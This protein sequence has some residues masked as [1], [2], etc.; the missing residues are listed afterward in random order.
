MQSPAAPTQTQRMSDAMDQD[1]A[2]TAGALVVAAD[3][4]GGALVTTTAD[5]SKQIQ[6]GRES[7]C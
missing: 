7:P 4:S 2:G 6:V 5:K 1:G 3:Q